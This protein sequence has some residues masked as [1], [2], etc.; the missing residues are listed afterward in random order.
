MPILLLFNQLSYNFCINLQTTSSITA[1]SSTKYGSLH[2]PVSVATVGQPSSAGTTALGASPF[3][4]T[5]SMA[6]GLRAS[7]PKLPSF[8]FKKRVEIEMQGSIP[9][10]VSSKQQNSPSPA[11][12]DS[13]RQRIDE[14]EA[15]SEH[16]TDIE[17]N[18]SRTW[19]KRHRTISRMEDDDR[20]TSPW[21]H[22]DESMDA[23]PATSVR[24]TEG[25]KI[26]CLV[27]ETVFQVVKFY[28]VVPLFSLKRL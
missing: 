13:K 28:T 3:D 2:E 25:I 6:L 7:L 5:H 9:Y 16:D 22:L 17:L 27:I 15:D 20:S 4:R 11:L 14:A 23:P 24:S 1:T 18:S 12:F 26:K 19:N 21:Q 8:K 10:E